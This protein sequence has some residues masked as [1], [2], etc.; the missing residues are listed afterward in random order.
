M[1]NNNSGEKHQVSARHL[2]LLASLTVLPAFG[3]YWGIG[4]GYQYSSIPYK[5]DI[6]STVSNTF[7]QI[8]Y[9][10]E[11]LFFRGQEA[12]I[13]AFSNHQTSVNVIGRRRFV[14]VPHALGN[15]YQEDAFDLGIQLN[16]QVSQL[17][18]WRLELLTDERWKKHLYAGHDWNFQVSDLMIQASAGLRLKSADYNSYYYGLDRHGGESVSSGAEANME[19]RFQYPL[20]A[21]WHLTGGIE[22]IQLEQKARSASTIDHDGYGSAKLGLLYLHGSSNSFGF[23]LPANSYIRF[24]HGWATA[25]DLSDIFTGNTRKDPYNNQIT[26]VFYGHPLTEDWLDLPLKTDVYLHSGLTIHQKSAVQ[27]YSLEGVVAIKFYVDVPWPVQWRFGLAEGLSY[28][29]HIAYIEQQEMDS[30]GYSP[31]KLMNYL[32]ISFDTSLGQFFNTPSLDSVWLGWSIHHR[33]AFFEQSSQ[34]GRIKGGSNYNT[35]YLQWHF[36]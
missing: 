26:S 16:Q 10:D 33:S 24:A 15:K 13:K 2:Y 20:A 35:I 12:G 21:G 17:R 36:Q 3:S 23:E 19:A 4:V 9:E 8:F 27:D 25:S 5:T 22:W 14:H 30:K 1:T 18:S 11:H 28:I 29:S 31:S 34:F 7:P 32:D 6:A